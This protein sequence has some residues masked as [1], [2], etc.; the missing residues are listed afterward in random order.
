MHFKKD[1]VLEVCI[2]EFFKLVV[3]TGKLKEG[4]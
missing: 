3:N 1:F 4:Q 2:L